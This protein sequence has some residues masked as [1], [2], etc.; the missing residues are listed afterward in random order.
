[1]IIIQNVKKKLK[2]VRCHYLTVAVISTIAFDILSIKNLE[3]ISK[4]K[5]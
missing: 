1:M 3:A 5:E 2:H 4:K